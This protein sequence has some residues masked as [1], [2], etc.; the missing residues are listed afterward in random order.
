MTLREAYINAITDHAVR[1][2]VYKEARRILPDIGARCAITQYLFLVRAGVLK[3][4]RPVPTFTTQIEAI[5]INECKAR[6]I[7]DASR[8]Q[9]GDVCFSRN[10]NGTP[11]PDHVYAM[12]TP[13]YPCE[14]SLVVDNYAID[15]HPR[16][17]GKGPRTPFD[18]AL[19]LP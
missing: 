2:W 12:H 4:R 17:I 18:Y 16:N 15:R 6:R 5:L 19:R 3:A 10:Q 9:R 14:P 7:T 13:V 1:A 11:G 8:L